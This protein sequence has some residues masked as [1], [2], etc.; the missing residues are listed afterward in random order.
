ERKKSALKPWNS[1]FLSLL[2]L[3]VWGHEN[4][5]S[6]M[7][8]LIKLTSRIVQVLTLTEKGYKFKTAIETRSMILHGHYVLDADSIQKIP[9]SRNLFFL[10]HAHAGSLVSFPVVG[11]YALLLHYECLYKNL[12]VY[13]IQLLHCASSLFC[14][15]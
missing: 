5:V 2:P 4:M 11:T 10:W 6:T 15:L 13:A 1:F 3:G 14:D 12:L 9:F 7:V 8:F